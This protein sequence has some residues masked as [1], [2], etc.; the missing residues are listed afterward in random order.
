MAYGAAD[1]PDAG[2]AHRVSFLI[3][4][5]GWLLKIYD[6]VDPATHPDEV[7]RDVDELG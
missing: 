7:L 2:F 4:E 5:D 3:D 6:K 1:A